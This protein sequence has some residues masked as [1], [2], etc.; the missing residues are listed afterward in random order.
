MRT[1]F[2]ASI[3]AL[4]CSTANAQCGPNGCPTTSR[5]NRTWLVMPA[6]EQAELTLASFDPVLVVQQPQPIKQAA[7][8]VAKPVVRAGKALRRGVR[9]ALRVL[10]G[11]RCRCGC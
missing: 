5:V 10:V 3:L 8:A 7:K 9:G 4:C 1:L 6:V 2:L 11:R